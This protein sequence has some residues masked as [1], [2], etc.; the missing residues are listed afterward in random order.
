[1]VNVRE[2]QFEKTFLGNKVVIFDSL[3]YVGSMAAN[4]GDVLTQKGFSFVKSY[5]HGQL[6][7]LSVGGASAAQTTVCWEGIPLNDAM[8]GS[9]DL[10]LVPFSFFSNVA[11]YQGGT[12]TLS[13]GNSLGGAINLK[14]KLQFKKAAGMKVGSDYSSLNNGNYFIDFNYAD[15]QLATHSILSFFSGLNQI[16][17][18]SSDIPEKIGTLPHANYSGLALMTNNAFKLS[19]NQI[20]RFDLWYQKYFRNLPPALY[21]AGSDAFQYDEQTRGLLSWKRHGKISETEIKTALFHSFMWYGDTVK[22]IDSRN[23]TTSFFTQ[24]ENLWQF[25]QHTGLLLRGEWNSFYVKTNNYLINKSRN[26][27]ASMIRF[28][29]NLLKDKWKNTMSVRFEVVDGQSIPVVFT[30]GSSMLLTQNF[31]GKINIAKNYRLPSFNDLYWYP[32]GNPNL[33][34]ENG[35]GY[36]SGI[37]YSL[38]KGKFLIK[39]ESTGYYNT[40]TDMI[41]WK[42]ETVSFWMPVNIGQ[43]KTHGVIM[44]LSV[45]FKQ[46]KWFARLDADYIYTKA[47]NNDITDPNYGN[48]LMYIP[49]SQI[50]L[51][52]FVS[53]HNF[54]LKYGQQIISPVFI[55]TGNEGILQGYVVANM[56]LSKK[57]AFGKK[58]FSMEVYGGVDNLFNENYQIMVARPMPL[59]YFKFGFIINVNQ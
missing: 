12:S 19:K 20:L 1:M 15:K 17:Y 38:S 48:E 58:Y 34:P 39:L 37:L 30:Y 21:E 56:L 45:V 23:N 53:Y 33:K 10:S 25:N 7:T 22:S 51:N 13:G 28:T 4:L 29:K 49:N 2:K 9:V 18:L 5:G 41:L 40:I 50:K 59:R 35:W 46:P 16:K 26:V 31:S 27:L 43:V 8:L 42:P 57:I 36:Q 24:A 14:N 52:G 44:N 54:L 3:Y 6:Q 32:M 47:I 55:S 11:L